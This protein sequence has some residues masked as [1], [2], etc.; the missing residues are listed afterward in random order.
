MRMVVATSVLLSALA[1]ALVSVRLHA[2]VMGL[3]YGIAGMERERDRLAGELRRALAELERARSPRAL[4]RLRAP[5]AGD[6]T[7]A[8]AAEG[9]AAMRGEAEDVE[10]EP[11]EVPAGE[12]VR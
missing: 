8:L 6:V 1:T 11:L 2:E 3:R 7:A 9:E 10:A 4:F 5:A 12:D